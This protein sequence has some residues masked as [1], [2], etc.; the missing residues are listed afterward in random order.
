MHVD[1]IEVDG[2]QMVCPACGK[3]LNIDMKGLEIIA[4]CCGAKLEA[5]AAT[6]IDL[7]PEKEN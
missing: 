7:L 6:L 1:D 4:L 2:E 5:D 3:P